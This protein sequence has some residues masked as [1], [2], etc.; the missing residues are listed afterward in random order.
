MSFAHYFG[1]MQFPKK[2]NKKTRNRRR[3]IGEKKGFFL[4]KKSGRSQGDVR[5][6]ISFFFVAEGACGVHVGFFTTTRGV[7]VCVIKKK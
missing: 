5:V 4:A 3:I 6:F 2:H 7:C 1:L